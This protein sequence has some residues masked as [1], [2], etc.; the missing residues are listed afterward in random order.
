MQLKDTSKFLFGIDY[1]FIHEI[2]IIEIIQG[3]GN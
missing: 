3:I 2:V 1:P